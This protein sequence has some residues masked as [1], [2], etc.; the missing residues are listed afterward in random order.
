MRRGKDF[1]LENSIRSA[2]I[3]PQ[4]KPS[5][6]FLHVSYYQKNRETE[7]LPPS[8]QSGEERRKGDRKDGEKEI[9][10]EGR[11]AGREEGRKKG[12]KNK[13]GTFLL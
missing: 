11:K 5:H 1:N 3:I 9:M 10:R 6:D 12:G 13:G 2:N 4:L 7:T 8:L